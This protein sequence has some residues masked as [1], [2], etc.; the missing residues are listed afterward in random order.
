MSALVQRQRTGQGQHIDLSA[1]EAI[2]HLIGHVFVQAAMTGE[3]PR[4][5][6]NYQE[7]MAPHNCYPCRGDDSWVSIAVGSDDEWQALV[8]VMGSPAWA[9]Q[10]RFGS[11]A[12][13][14]LH[15]EELDGRVGEWTRDRDPYEV[16]S[17]L[18]EAGVAA[19]PSLSGK[20]VST[21][22]HLKARKGQVEV[23]HPSLGKQVVFGP[24][25]K[26]S[27]TPPQVDS[28]APL[29]GQHNEYVLKGL[30]GLSSQEIAALKKTGVL[31]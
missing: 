28:P 26:F 15:R 6:G 25:W 2:S 4:R 21:D 8:R 10:K 3:E 13:R 14:I 23:E 9:E 5:Q 7:G 11:P 30:L 18:Q 17:I 12:A 20:D 31:S 27:L 22:P 1:R 24:P 29:L 16:T 19:F